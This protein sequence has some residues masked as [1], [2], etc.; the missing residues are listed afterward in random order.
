M[1]LS[2]VIPTY[3]EVQNVPILYAELVG[4]LKQLKH[5]YEIIFIDDGSTDGTRQRLRELHKHDKN[6]KVV[7]HKMNS[8]QT[9]AM[10]TGFKYAHGDVIITMDADLQ[11]DPADIPKLLRKMQ[12]GYDVVSGWRKYRRDP[13]T[14]KIVS[15]FAHFLRSLMAT[16]R[17]HDSG[18]TLKAYKKE[19]F[20]GLDLYGEMHRYIPS[21]LTWRGFRVGEIVV[22]HR[23]RKHGRTKYGT[24]RLF[25]GFLDLFVIKFWMQ[26]SFRPMHL[27]GGIGLMFFGIGALVSVYLLL[28][29]FFYNQSLSDRPLL[30][31]AALMILLGFQL[32]MLGVL[33]DALTKIY[34]R[35]NPIHRTG[36]I[37]E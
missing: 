26:Y 19:C 20:D 4:V 15:K 28:L 10:D 32:F 33:M 18:C 5:K 27:F 36:E 34:Y 1:K 13:I 14:K 3:N 25:R 7:F 24:M 6:V 11:N 8:G 21:L 16:E 9:A 2:V 35:Q 23:A 37:L 22:N 12:E 30:I 31:L 29:K 17:I